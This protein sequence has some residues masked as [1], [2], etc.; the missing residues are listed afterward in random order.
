MHDIIVDVRL[1]NAT[2]KFL[3]ESKDTKVRNSSEFGTQRDLGS[4]INSQVNR[5]ASTRFLV[6]EGPICRLTMRAK[7]AGRFPLFNSPIFTNVA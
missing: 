2:V 7:L 3:C 1:L 6:L 4:S 5:Y